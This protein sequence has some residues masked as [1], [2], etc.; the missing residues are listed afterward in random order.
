MLKK[1]TKLA[2]IIFLIIALCSTFCLATDG[3]AV[4]TSLDDTTAVE[5]ISTGD[6]ATD[7]VTDEHV[8][9]EIS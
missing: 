5:D 4:V 3:E 6:E 2:V 7:E 1:Q 8:D 9:E